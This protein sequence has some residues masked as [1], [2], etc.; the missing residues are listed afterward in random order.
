MPQLLPRRRRRARPAHIHPR[1]PTHQ[2]TH[3]PAAR[4]SATTNRRSRRRSRRV[5]QPHNI[6]HPPTGRPR[7]GR[8]RSGHPIGRARPRRVLLRASGR[9]AI[10][11]DIQQI[12]DIVLRRGTACRA[13]RASSTGIH[14]RDRRRDGV[15]GEVLALLLD[16]GALDGFGAEA[17]LADER[18]GRLVVDRGEGGEFREEALEEGGW[19][20]SYGGGDGGL[21][22]ENDVL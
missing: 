1:K 22:S 7:P 4:G 21:L 12:L 9:G 3:P 14:G 13:V 20:G 15:L 6:R 5:K 10:K 18:L 19:E 16:G 2:I 8:N 17:A 11:V